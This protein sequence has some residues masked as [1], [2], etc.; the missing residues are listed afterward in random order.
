VPVATKPLTRL[1]VVPPTP[2]I[3][4]GVEHIDGTGLTLI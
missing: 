3:V 2:R 4:D 1:P